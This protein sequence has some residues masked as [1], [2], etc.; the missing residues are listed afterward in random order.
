[1]NTA[2]EV[3]TSR[4]LSET[5]ETHKLGQQRHDQQQGGG[6]VNLGSNV[7]TFDT[8]LSPPPRTSSGITRD[9]GRVN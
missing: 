6:K 1:M 7:V 8:I 4:A 3:S 2:R 9:W 5:E